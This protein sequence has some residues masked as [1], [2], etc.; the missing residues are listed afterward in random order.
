MIDADIEANFDVIAAIPNAVGALCLNQAGIQMLNERPV[1][2][3]LFALFTSERHTKVLADRENASLFGSGIDELVRHQ[4]GLKQSVLDCILS[5]LAAI[6][7]AGEAYE[8]RDSDK[9]RMYK[10]QTVPPTA[11]PANDEVM[12]EAG[13]A[14]SA[15]Q[16]TAE[17]S[18]SVALA[19]VVMD[20]PDM[21][22]ESR[23]DSGG[24]NAIVSYIDV[25]SRFLDGL[26]QTVQHCKDFLKADGLERLLRFYRLPCLPY[27]FVNSMGN[28]SLVTLIRLIV[29]VSPQSVLSA[30]LRELRKSM[31]ECTDLWGADAPSLASLLSPESAE[32]AEAATKTFRRLVRLNAHSHL[33]ADVGPTFVFAGA[34]LPLVFLQTV[35]SAS[36]PTGRELAS[37]AEIGELQ[38]QAAWQNVCLKAVAPPGERRKPRRYGRGARAADANGATADT[39]SGANETSETDLQKVQ[40]LQGV[41]GQSSDGADPGPLTCNS[42]ALRYVAASLPSALTTFLV[43]TTRLFVLRRSSDQSLRRHATSTAAAIAGVVTKSLAWRDSE[44]TQNSF[45]YACAMIGQATSLLYDDRAGAHP[46]TNTLVLI[47]FVREGG[48][49]ALL[50]LYTRYNDEITRHFDEDGKVREVGVHDGLRLGHIYS[51]LGACLKMLHLLSAHR[52]LMDP[53]ATAILTSKDDADRRAAEF[54]LPHEFLVRLRLAILPALRLTWDSKWLPNAPFTL[55]RSVNQTMLQI[56]LGEGEAPAPRREGASSGSGA[57]NGSG[58]NAQ[59]DGVRQLNS[60]QAALA[61][62]TGA[63]GGPPPGS[64]AHGHGHDFAQPRSRLAVQPDEN[65]TRELTDMGFP[66]AAARAALTRCNNNLALAADYLLSVSLPAWRR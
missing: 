66:R 45:A 27:D 56:L 32:A 28:D 47:A 62:L 5:T 52:T 22:L 35:N 30:I 44:Q 31:T 1:V 20:E 13:G 19:D 23:D 17:Q 49:D 51:G 55:N 64:R 15:T 58:S 8:L 18:L 34:K 9:K 59:P 53:T 11:A 40:G 39:P 41:Q 38:R 12:Q 4:P 10:L 7:A 50:G 37:I 26:F 46:T 54:F 63:L 33:L 21:S 29:E 24:D 60:I 6:Y 61:G 42:T 48:L 14:S 25:M 43:E 3:K 2:P 57:A 36:S 16:V 65:R